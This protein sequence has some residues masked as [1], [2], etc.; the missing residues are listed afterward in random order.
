[1]LT[2]KLAGLIRWLNN[3]LG[4]GGCVAQLYSTFCLLPIGTSHGFAIMFLLAIEEQYIDRN[5][6]SVSAYKTATFSRREIGDHFE[7][8]P[9]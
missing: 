9:S 4:N 1:L 3:P 6:A 5:L 2:I 7:L 8:Q